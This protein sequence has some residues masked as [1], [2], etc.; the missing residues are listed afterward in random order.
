MTIA[1]ASGTGGTGKTT[2]AVNLAV[3]SARRGERVALVDCDV[4][5]PDAHLFLPVRKWHEQEVKVPIAAVDEDACTACG[6]CSDV[7]AAGAIRVLGDTAV[8]F[9]ELCRSC[10]RCVA[11]C[12][13]GA[14]SM[15]RHRVGTV[16][17]AAAPD[18][19]S[20]LELV[21]G[22]LD[23]G[24]VRAPDVIRAAREV[25]E[26]LPAEMVILDASPGVACAATTA[27]RGADVALLVT[28]P[29]AFGL[30]DLD[31]ALRLTEAIGVP[32]SVVVN[33]NG[34]G[35]ADVDALCEDAG[36]PVIARFP[37]DRAVAEVY[38]HGGLLVDEHEDSA[39]RF[40]VLARWALSHVTAG[41]VM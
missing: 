3:E 19:A 20:D 23:V 28:E 6:A 30:H 17:V 2:V 38:A 40:A 31:A 18:A 5:E 29:T 36:V 25:A 21:W 32:A 16:S 1:I 33:R 13:T 14:V 26:S 37:F 9:D 4:E 34:I 39:E 12:P 22:T 41:G 24:E 35:E 10:E 11:A 8:V 27:L 15:K 7:C